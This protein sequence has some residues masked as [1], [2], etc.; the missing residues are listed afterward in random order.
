M[1]NETIPIAAIK[2]EL[3]ELGQWR[4]LATKY[5]GRSEP[6]SGVRNMPA[7]VEAYIAR[8]LA[9]LSEAHRNAE[10]ARLADKRPLDDDLVLYLR[11][12]RYQLAH[13]LAEIARDERKGHIESELAR[14]HR[15]MSIGQDEA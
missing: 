5:G 4:A 8:L 11:D 1:S 6:H 2:G 9:A 14:V 7:D 10:K 3:M 12:R 15:L 13:E